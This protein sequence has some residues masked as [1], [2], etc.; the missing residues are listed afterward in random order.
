VI[1][2][3][4]RWLEAFC[5][6]HADL[7]LGAPLSINFMERAYL[8]CCAQLGNCWLARAEVQRLWSSRGEASVDQRRWAG[9]LQTAYT[10]SVAELAFAVVKKWSHLTVIQ[11]KPYMQRQGTIQGATVQGAP[12]HAQCEGFLCSG[13]AGGSRGG[14]GGLGLSGN[15]L[16]S[17]HKCHSRLQ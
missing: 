4:G 10:L 8:V 13:C 15:H 11:M 6:H 16:A 17:I 2:R 12:R 3:L 7:L 1:N 14:P 5:L 9:T